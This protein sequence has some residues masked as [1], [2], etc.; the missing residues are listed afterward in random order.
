MPLMLMTSLLLAGEVPFRHVVIDPEP[1][2]DPHCKAVGDLNGEWD[3]R[4]PPAASASVGGLFCTR[5]RT[6]PS[7]DR[8]RAIT[9]D[10]AVGDMTTTAT[11][12][13]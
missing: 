2:L 8:R 5:R 12:T 10:M 4:P 6:G 13:W 3:D 11:S 1:P 9:T 7:T